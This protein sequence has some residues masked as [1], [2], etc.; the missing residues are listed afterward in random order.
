MSGYL[1]S[2]FPVAGYE[3]LEEKWAEN[4]KDRKTF[5]FLF[6]KM[7]LSESGEAWNINKTLNERSEQGS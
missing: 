1:F 6:P 3:P 7:L 4:I 5:P 2:I